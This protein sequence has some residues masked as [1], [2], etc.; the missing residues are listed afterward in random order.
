M[1]HTGEIFTVPNV[2]ISNGEKSF[3]TEFCIKFPDGKSYTDDDAN[4]LTES[5][6]KL[7]MS[8]VYTLTYSA[9]IEGKYYSKEVKF[10][11]KSK[12]YSTSG[13]K[14]ITEYGQASYKNVYDENTQTRTGLKLNLATGEEFAYNEVIDLIKKYNL[15]DIEKLSVDEQV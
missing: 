10:T 9:T 3:D 2:K 4:P 12:L 7:S 5:Q 1:P 6:Y 14:S 8:G 11:V 13:N 15:E